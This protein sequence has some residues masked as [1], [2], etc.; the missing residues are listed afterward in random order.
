[1]LATKQELAANVDVVTIRGALSHALAP[2]HRIVD[3]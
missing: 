2:Q 1:M 3:L